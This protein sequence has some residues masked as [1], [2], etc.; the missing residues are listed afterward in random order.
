MDGHAR[1]L[2]LD[3]GASGSALSGGVRSLGGNEGVVD[4][5]ESTMEVVVREELSTFVVNLDKRAVGSSGIG[6]MVER[7]GGGCCQ[8]RGGASGGSSLL[9]LVGD[10]I[11]P[12]VESDRRSSAINT[13]ERRVRPFDERRR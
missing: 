6:E 1:W 5:G 9:G 8:S 7:A 12:L 13:R 11:D 4:S 10:R 2:G 3:E